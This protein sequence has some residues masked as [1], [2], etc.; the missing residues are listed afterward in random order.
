MDKPETPASSQDRRTFL[1]TAA[2]A[3]GAAMLAPEISAEPSPKPPA[4]DLDEM[5]IADL[6]KGLSSGKFTVRSLTE[7]YLARITALDKD[8]SGPAVNAVIQLNPDALQIADALD[9]ER[10]TNKPRGPLHGIEV[11]LIE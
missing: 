11:M 9:K 6:Q 8:K 1:K 3:S 2:M 10:H 7:K 4:F 5:T